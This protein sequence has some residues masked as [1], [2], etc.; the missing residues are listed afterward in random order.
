ML[1]DVDESLDPVAVRQ[2]KIDQEQIHPVPLQRRQTLLQRARGDRHKVTVGRQ[3]HL[4]EKLQV[5]LIVLDQQDV[6]GLT[7]HAV[8]SRL[9][10][11]R[12]NL[13][14]GWG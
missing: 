13:E 10:R 3:Q 5:L 4:R 8:Q 9:L 11:R 1:D 12:R 7:R 14:V 2:G 6:D